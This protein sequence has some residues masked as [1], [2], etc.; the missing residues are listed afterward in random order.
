MKSAYHAAILGFPVIRTLEDL[1]VFLRIPVE[2]ISRL[3]RQKHYL[4]YFE[5]SIQKKKSGRFRKISCP[6][7]TLK[8]VQSWILVNI[9]NKLESHSASTAFDPGC[10]IK[11]NA[12]QH[13]NQKYI[14]NV[15][16][17]DFF[18][19]IS[20]FKVYSIFSAI[21]YNK[22]IA[23]ALT[24]LTTY[25]N[26][27]PQGAPS[28]PKL[29]NLVCFSLD[30]RISGF[31]RKYNLVYTRYSDDITIS[32]SDRKNIKRT[33]SFLK[34]V[35]S[36]E[37]LALREEKT[38]VFGSQR[39]HIITGLIVHQEV[40]VG[41]AKLHQLRSLYFNAAK[42]KNVKDTQYVDAY[43]NFLKFVDLKS[44]KILIAYKEKTIKKLARFA[45]SSGKFFAEKKPSL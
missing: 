42:E 30:S 18:Q 33:L 27:L 39:P 24:A 31:C 11:H 2:S 21:G 36:D 6:N 44:A 12:A 35:T 10:S 7:R 34:Y 40:R 43:I 32:T 41:R 19:N 8:Y 29:A 5:F 3:I 28:S 23:S 38:N 26:S 22:E 17:E 37:G 4:G 25:K 9:L 16:V 20:S 13:V 14:I 1:S 45:D 15:D